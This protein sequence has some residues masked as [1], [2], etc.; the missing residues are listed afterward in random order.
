MKYSFKYHF[1][2]IVGM[3]LFA[4][5]SS[6]QQSERARRKNLRLA[7]DAYE[8]MD[9]LRAFNYYKDVIKYDTVN[10]EAIFRS[11]YCLFAINKT[12]TASL[13]YFLRAKSKV[14]EAHFFIGR[15]FLLKGQAR[16]ALEEFYQFKLINT[17]GVINNL[18]VLTWIRTCEAALEEE[19]KQHSLTVKNLGGT[20][21][22][23]YPEYVAIEW[24][25]NGYLVFTSRRNDSKGG[26]TDPYGKYYEDI[27]VARKVQDSWESPKSISENINTDSHDA[28]VAFSPDGKELLIYRTDERQSGGD[29]YISRFDGSDWSVPEKLGP[30][31]NSEYL[32]TSACFSASGNEIIFSSNRPGGYGGMD[33]YV[34]RKFMNG[35]Y[36]LPYNLGAY[37]NTKEDEDAPFIARSNNALYF[38]SKGHN[39]IGEYDIFVSEYD[40]D[41]DKWG[42]AETMGMP[43]NSTSDDI[44]FTL[45]E[46]E[47]SALFTSRREGG[48]GEADIYQINF[49][50][51]TQT[52]VLLRINTEK[53]SDKAALNDIQVSL[54]DSETGRLEGLYRPNREYMTLV[55]VASVNKTYKMILEGAGLEPIITKVVFNGVDKEISVDVNKKTDL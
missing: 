50:E 55:M 18:E 44:Y 36:S 35:K 30:E 33:L 23:A 11:G 14:P 24:P 16:K 43:I 17:E 49:N 12:D 25:L 52:T 4:Q 34:T 53:I 32:E 3:L 2:L 13:K 45:M 15:I 39:S 9:Y 47:E 5:L 27:Y 1:F 42:K 6:A 26:L 40:M 21:N 51:S 20:I 38:S 28:C 46:D 19:A 10:Y 8:R 37:I 29:L 22:T 48:F 41:L 54:Y 31:V 7:D